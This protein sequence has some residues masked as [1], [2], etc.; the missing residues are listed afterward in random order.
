MTLSTVPLKHVAVL[1][2][3]TLSENTDPEFSFRYID[4]ASTGRGSLREDPKTITFRAAPSRA[5]RVLRPGDSIL[6][7]VRTY[8]RAAWTVPKG[9]DRIVASTG[10]V[11]LRPRQEIDSGY[12]GWAIQSDIVVEEIIARSVGVSYPA[13]APSEVGQIRIPRPRPAGQRAI[14]D[15]LDRETRRVDALISEK[16]WMVALLAEAEQRLLLDLCGDWRAVESWSLRQAGAQVVTGPFGT[17]LS[18]AE[19]I[20]DGVPVINPTHISAVGEIRPD[21][22]VSVSEGVANRLQRHRVAPGD[23]V[24]GR[25]GDVG[26]S[27][28]VSPDQEGWLCGSD[29]IAVRTNSSTLNPHFLALVLHIGLYRQQLEARST[30][31]MMANL[32]EDSLLTF[33]LPRLPLLAQKEIVAEK[34]RIIKGR[35]QAATFI[36]RT[37]DLLQEHR[38][39]LINTA[40]AG[41]LDIPDAV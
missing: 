22:R 41:Q 28:V 7:T 40:V 12:L 32:N 11:C 6:S 37:I 13:I 15:F 29:S 8:L 10:F 19:Y 3:E 35:R 14:A 27:A 20:D 2:P 39:R 5:R 30:G 34:E 33:R 25:K 31:A 17:Q 1:N 16:E 24:L 26:R 18:A 9:E 23:V 4:I 21:P 36:S 38:R